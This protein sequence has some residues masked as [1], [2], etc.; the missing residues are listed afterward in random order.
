MKI[1]Y[2]FTLIL[3]LTFFTGCSKNNKGT[4]NEFNDFSNDESSEKEIL[5]DINESDGIEICSTNGNI[6]VKNSIEIYP[7]IS[8]R[9]LSSP[10]KMGQKVKKGD[11][12]AIIDPS[13]SGANYSLYKVTSPI[14]GNLLTIPIQCGTIANTENKIAVVGD[15]SELQVIAYIPERFYSYLKPGLKAEIRVEAFLDEKFTATL[16]EVSPVIDE[17]SRTTEVILSIDDKGTKLCAGMFADI[18]LYLDTEKGKENGSNSK[19]SK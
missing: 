19:N 3:I 13:I 17:A 15:L 10:M 16:Q 1:R 4:E 14:N 6:R 12:I 2:F 11:V 18:D 8:G 5:I 9:V 7:V